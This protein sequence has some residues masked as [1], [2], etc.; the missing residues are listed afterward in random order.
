MR[1][2]ARVNQQRLR[3]LGKCGDK[4]GHAVVDGCGRISEQPA[5]VV[6]GLR[7]FA[8][9]NGGRD[10]SIIANGRIGWRIENVVCRH[11]ADQVPRKFEPRARVNIHTRIMPI[12]P[13][14]ITRPNI[15]IAL[16]R[17]SPPRRD[18]IIIERVPTRIVPKVNRIPFAANN[19]V[20]L[21]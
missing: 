6:I 1:V 10:K 7:R 13:K 11:R 3:R 16:L 4:C 12:A 2:N 8:E 18:E 5:H 21:K 17:A 9:R 14:H 19:N 20:A 15:V